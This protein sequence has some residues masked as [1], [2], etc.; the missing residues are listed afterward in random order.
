[1]FRNRQNQIL[2]QIQ[3]LN[4]FRKTVIQTCPCVQPEASVIDERSV[5]FQIKSQCLVRQTSW[6]RNEIDTAPIYFF[7]WMAAS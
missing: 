7:P 2:G 6:T 5:H 3:D 1:M 4:I